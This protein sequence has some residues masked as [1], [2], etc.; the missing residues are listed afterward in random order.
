[1][2]TAVYLRVSTQEQEL[3]HQARELRELIERRGWTISETYAEKA[4]AASRRPEL[5]RLLNDARA[6]RFQVV[7]VWALD[8]LGRSML[9]LFNLV[10]ELERAGVGVVFLRQ[11]EL[12]TTGPHRRLLLAIWSHLAELERDL[13][14]TRTRAGL[15]TAK[16]RGVRIGRPRVDPQPAQVT[17]LVGQ[18]NPPAR[19]ARMLGVSRST[20]YR[21]LS[22]T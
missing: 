9:E 4:S 3:E 8:R 21:L 22:K 18:G 11:P 1:M 5:E 17:Y 13:I 7:A 2:R 20:I 16:R 6:R 19:V 12:D 14:R 10:D 15:E